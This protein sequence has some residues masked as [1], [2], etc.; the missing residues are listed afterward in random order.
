[1]DPLEPRAL[2]AL[3]TRRA[4]EEQSGQEKPE[5]EAPVDPRGHLSSRRRKIVPA[6]IISAAM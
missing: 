6:K 1:M 4:R 2:R 3:E 5:H